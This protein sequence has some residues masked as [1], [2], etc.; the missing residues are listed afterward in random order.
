WPLSFSWRATHDWSTRTSSLCGPS[1]RVHAPFAGAGDREIQK[2]K[3]KQHRELTLIEHWVETLWRVREKIGD[4]HE[5]GQDEGHRPRE[6]AD[7]HQ[8]ATDQLEH[9][10]RAEERYELQTVEGFEMR[11]AEE[12]RGA[13]LQQQQRSHDAKHGEQAR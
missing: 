3:A 10:C 4:R 8:Q 13:M 6:Q 1:R 12:L 9:A 11:E 7:Q 5:A 2:E